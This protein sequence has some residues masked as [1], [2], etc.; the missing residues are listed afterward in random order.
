MDEE[1]RFLK[2][3]RGDISIIRRLQE[4]VMHDAAHGLL[5]RTGMAVGSR[6]ARNARPYKQQYFEA[7]KRML[8]DE[9]WAK[10]IQ[11]Q[12]DTITVT[13]SIETE[14]GARNTCHMLRGVIAKVYEGYF[15]KLMT[16]TEVDCESI[17]KPKCVFRVGFA[18]NGGKKAEIEENGN[19]AVAPPAANG[20]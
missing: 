3:R 6:I 10:D 16:C 5:F 13:S 15:G 4:S 12:N 19:G 20:L 8:V 18:N 2:Y 14:K 7:A 9:G 11:F 17:G 1:A